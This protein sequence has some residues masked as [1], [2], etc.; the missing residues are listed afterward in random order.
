MRP[1]DFFANFGCYR[2]S[3][4]ND[5]SVS[6]GSNAFLVTAPATLGARH[7]ALAVTIS[8]FV[9][10]CALIPFARIP[11]PRIE[12]FNPFFESTLVL[13]GLVTTSFLLVGF[14][15]SRLRAV[16]CLASGYLFTSL[17]A[18]PLMLTSPGVFSTSGPSNPDAQISAWLDTF[19]NAGFPLFVICYALLRR[20][21]VPSGRSHTGARAAV[22]WAAAGVVAG[23]CLLSL[24]ASA[25]HQLLPRLML[26]DSYTTAMM[27]LNIPVCLLGLAAAAVL[28]SRPPYSILDL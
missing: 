19:R 5:R 15:R 25:G 4:V 23:I 21:E 22:I 13:N 16:L 8:L 28:V 14:R 3:N 12:A 18:I 17:M 27:A 20:Y 1:G 11:L 26:G 9:A 7:R 24:V 6:T 10:F 2:S